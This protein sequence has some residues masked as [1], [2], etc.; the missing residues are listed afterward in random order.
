[1][2]ATA[3]NRRLLTTAEIKNMD[4]LGSPVINVA[5]LLISWTSSA[6]QWFQVP[7]VSMTT[8]YVRA[9]QLIDLAILLAS[10]WF[11]ASPASA[12]VSPMCYSAYVSGT[13]TSEAIGLPLNHGIKVLPSGRF[14]FCRITIAGCFVAG[15]CARFPALHRILSIELFLVIIIIFIITRYSR[16]R[17]NKTAVT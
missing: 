10:T 11:A 16:K 17:K 13:V 14:P 3:S 7:R 15:I 8:G 6:A 5:R 2:A 1:M 9:G 12:A 4:S